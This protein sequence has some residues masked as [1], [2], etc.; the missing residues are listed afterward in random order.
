MTDEQRG[1]ALFQPQPTGPGQF[2]A[3]RRSQSLVYGRYTML[4]RA[5]PDKKLTPAGMIQIV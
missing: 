4:L 3:R 5:L 1:V 2:S